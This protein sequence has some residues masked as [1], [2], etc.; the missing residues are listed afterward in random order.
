MYFHR[1]IPHVTA[2]DRVMNSDRSAA[3]ERS[4]ESETTIDDWR[5]RFLVAGASVG[6]TLLAGC[7]S[8]TDPG[9]SDG[10]ATSTD[11][12][13]GDPTASGG[14]TT[15]Y[16]NFRLLIS[17]QPV[18]IDEFDSLVVTLDRARVFRTEGDDGT[19]TP[20]GNAT[21]TP[22][23]DGN[24]TATSTA[25]P[26]ET[27]TPD[28]D[29]QAGGED[30]DQRGF[31]IVDLDGAAVDLTRVVGDKAITVFDG[32]LPT[33]RYT[34]IELYAAEVD[35][36]VDGETVDVTIP[37]GKLQI[38]KPFEVVAGESVDFVSDINVVKRGNAGGYNLLPVISESGVAGEDVEVTEIED[39][40]D[41]GDADE[42]PQNG[43]DA[44]GNAGGR[45]GD[46]STATDE[47]A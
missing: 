3:T 45:A 47:D 5:R 36:V 41:G 1:G 15:A 2:K 35:G 27:P 10:A 20:T 19:A 4:S 9:E 33:G 39:R 21:A 7:A 22:T 43:S 32:D 24:G 26:T 17:D 46:T 18:A 38:T 13:G 30:G 16:G 34:K 8:D 44:D 25:T 28:G 40:T 29:G 23:P 12:T 11:A 31:S 6:A 37:S 42:T 14:T